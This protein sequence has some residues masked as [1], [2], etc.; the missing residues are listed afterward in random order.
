[1]S[2]LSDS[3]LQQRMLAFREQQQSVLL[4]TLDS[5]QNPTAS[6]APFY[7][8]DGQFYIFISQLAE[9]T[10]NLQQHPQA[11]LLLIADEQDSANI[12][13][14]QRLSY[15]CQAHEITRD[16]AEY[17]AILDAF[18]HKVGKMLGLLRGLGDFHL[19]ALKPSSGDYVEGFG[20][21][22]RLC[23]VLLDQLE[24]RRN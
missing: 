16:S 1:M 22:Y 13:A 11:S 4:A 8:A 24:Q 15:R 20:K 10:Q 3:E 6:Y 12:F 5:A 23:G 14:R 21:A 7:F 17:D 2:D 19:Y 18:Q 9:H